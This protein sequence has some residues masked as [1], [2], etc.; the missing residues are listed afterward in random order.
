MRRY[1]AQQR[2]HD[3]RQPQGDGDD[4]LYVVRV[5]LPPVLRRQDDERAFDAEEDDLQD[6]LD[7]RADVQGGDRHFAQ[8]PDHDVV[9]QRDAEGDDVL[10]DDWNRQDDQILVE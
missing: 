1:A 5:A 9:R 8:L 10:E 2:R 7:L 6:A 4:V 3:E